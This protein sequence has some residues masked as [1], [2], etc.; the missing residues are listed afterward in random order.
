MQFVKSTLVL[1]PSLILT[2]AL[3][4]C[5]ID[6]VPGGASPETAQASLAAIPTTG[7][8]AMLNAQRASAGL[9]PASADARL[10]A[11]AQGHAE[12]MLAQ[13]YFSHTGLDGRSSAQRV[14]AAGYSSCRPS[15]NIAFGQISEAELLQG[16]VASPG[17]L[18]N[19]MMR[20]PVQ[21]G[22]GRAGTKWVLVVAGVC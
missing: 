13:D 22:L 16:W 14:R 7:F 15:E 6:S 8:G 19:I 20:G 1:A 18:A 17:H 4:G 5:T 12:D 2:L 11:A 9:P 3:S 10:T 21:Y